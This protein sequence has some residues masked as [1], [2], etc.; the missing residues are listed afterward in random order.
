MGRDR[1]E[2]IE[3]IFQELL[4]LPTE[5]RGS[6]L[7]ERCGDDADLKASVRK[8]LEHYESAHPEFLEEPVFARGA[9]EDDLPLSVGSYKVVRR[10]GEG[11]M[12]VIYEA[13]QEHP[14]R[15]V[16]VKVLRAGLY[17]KS[18]L[19]RFRAEWDALGRLNHPGIAN[20]YEAGSGD[21]VFENFTI[22]L[23]YL[24][25]ELVDGRSLIEYV[26]GEGLDR[27]LR[28]SLFTDICEAIRHAHEQSV[29]HRD[30]KPSN[31]VVDTSG[32][33]KV[34]DFGVARIT[35]EQ[36]TQNTRTGD[37]IGTVRYMSPE[38]L[39]GSREV[40]ARSDIYSLGVMLFELLTGASPYGDSDT[41]ITDRILWHERGSVPRVAR[42]DPSLRGDM[43]AIVRMAMAADPGERYQSAEALANDVRRYLRGEPVLAPAESRWAAV[44]RHVRRR[45]VV[46]VAA[47]VAVVVA[48]AMALQSGGPFGTGVTPAKGIAAGDRLAVMYFENLSDTSDSDRR[49]EIVTELLISGLSQSEHLNVVSSQRLHD[50]LD[51]TGT[52]DMKR[53]DRTMATKLAR[54]A[55][56]RWMMQG[57][58]VQTDPS[59]VIASEIVDVKTGDVASSL[60][61]TGSIGESIFSIADRITD[62]TLDRLAIPDA[63]ALISEADT[64]ARSEEAYRYYLEG[65]A[66]KRKQYS[67]EA[68]ESFLKAL[69][70]D[71]T[72][73]QAAYQLGIYADLSWGRERGELRAQAL[74]HVGRAPWRDQQYIR[75]L[76]EP[77]GIRR[78]AKAVLGRFPNDTD[79]LEALSW[80]AEGDE[81]ISYGTRLIEIDPNN[82]IGYNALAY[83][84][85][86]SGDLEKALW[87]VDKYGEL[88]PGEPNVYDTRG[89]IYA[90]H[91]RLDE[92]IEEYATA[93]RIKPDFGNHSAADKL[94]RLYV[95]RGQMDSATAC[96]SQLLGSNEA[97]NRARGRTRM[98]QL[99]A[100]TGQVDESLRQIEGA[101]TVD[102]LE[103]LE[104]SQQEHFRI[105]LAALLLHEVGED[106]KAL[107][108]MVAAWEG[109][110]ARWWGPGTA[111]RAGF[112]ARI[113]DTQTSLQLL[114]RFEAEVDSVTENQALFYNGARGLH[115]LSLG[116]F[117][118]AAEYLEKSRGAPENTGGR[119]RAYI[120]AARWE[121]A[122]EYLER[123]SADYYWNRLEE[124]LEAARFHYYL[125]VAYHEVGR[126]DEAIARLEE[127]LEIWKDADP[128]LQGPEDARRRLALL[129]RTD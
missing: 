2:K 129:R 76:G 45:Q 21:V 79:A 91:G 38:Q 40:D 95:Y 54:R 25:M 43:D 113:G 108:K 51:L 19:S 29:V 99:L 41:S 90:R 100:Y 84:Y 106:E 61:T 31:I 127:F 110:G 3:T 123:L 35:D 66:H 18:Q 39:F 47:A 14:R 4:D 23:P 64:T 63:E 58:I 16:A 87:A 44:R 101:N 77:G 96:F 71:S 20:V 82:E 112:F 1:H 78:A 117:D 80:R 111:V 73:A 42:H 5:D 11:G 12:G 37:V 124:P 70:A 88:A 109:L 83:A 103:K 53:I 104:F 68:R 93:V 36:R 55:S 15:R 75:R 9:S 26:T 46:Y 60:R 56:A 10:L 121:D 30:L 72:F 102:R 27:T 34:L 94:G 22:E 92:A 69:R 32:N 81:R 7:D 17:S 57:R 118:E 122:I 119:V 114:K 48:V 67:Q 33:A 49:G 89:E 74:R 85:S 13:E 52:G 98:V 59:F 116:N 28:L 50:L 62:A 8:L 126:T 120:G 65:L 6:A 115:E 97:R 105:R 24:A 125:G 86:S 107:S 128:R